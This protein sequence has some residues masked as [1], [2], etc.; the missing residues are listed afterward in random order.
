MQTGLSAVGLSAVPRAM[1][2]GPVKVSPPSS[3][4]YSRISMRAQS[5]QV[6]RASQQM[7]IVPRDVIVMPGMR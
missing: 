2:T 6:S 7:R 1:T 3:E 4:R 5:L